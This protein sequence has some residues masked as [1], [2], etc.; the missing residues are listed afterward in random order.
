MKI[1][2]ITAAAALG[3]SIA[4]GGAATSTDAIAQST[5][6]K[7]ATTKKAAPK[8]T[9]RKR[10]TKRRVVRPGTLYLTFYNAKWSQAKA[11]KCGTSYRLLNAAQYKAVSARSKKLYATQVK[12]CGATYWIT[13]RAATCRSA[14][15]RARHKEVVRSYVRK[16]TYKATCPRGAQASIDK[17]AAARKANFR[18]NSGKKKP[19][20]KPV[21]VKKGS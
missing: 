5:Q 4:L 2:A 12:L 10:T 3:L 1:A 13:K 11:G 17:A 20:R 8:K 21:P 16:G 14:H 15:S 18:K 6:K 19:A 9:V 7:P